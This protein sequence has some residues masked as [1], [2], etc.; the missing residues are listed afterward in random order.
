MQR[1]GNIN[2]QQLCVALPSQLCKFIR[3]LLVSLEVDLFETLQLSQRGSCYFSPPHLVRC[4]LYRGSHESGQLCQRDLLVMNP[5]CCARNSPVVWCCYER[6]AVRPEWG[7]KR[8][9]PGLQFPTL[10]SCISLL[11][12]RCWKCNNKPKPLHSKRICLEH[13]VIFLLLREYGQK[14]G[15]LMLSSSFLGQINTFSLSL[16]HA[17]NQTLTSVKRGPITAKTKKCAGTITEASDA[18]PET[19][20]RCLTPR[21][22]K[23][24]ENHPVSFR[25]HSPLSH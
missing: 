23:S 6:A 14:V 1:L 10:P 19:P 20:V 16:C 7:C 4:R 9:F 5:G 25:L 24:T 21:P 18:I 13:E 3:T 2:T 17:A 11:I 22:L 8:G 12:H 15:V